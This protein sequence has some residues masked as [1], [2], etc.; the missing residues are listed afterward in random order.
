MKTVSEFLSDWKVYGDDK[1]FKAALNAF[2]DEA[3]KAGYRH[4]LS[5]SKEQQILDSPSD[6]SE[7]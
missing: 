2:V 1:E 5:V 3:Y 6:D 4:G 7:V